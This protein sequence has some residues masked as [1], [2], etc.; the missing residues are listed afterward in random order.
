[1]IV[2]ATAAFLTFTE[3]GQGVVSFL[4]GEFASLFGFVQEIIG[5]ISDAFTAGDW[6][7]AAAIAWA[8]VLVAWEEA[9]L[10][11]FNSWNSMLGVWDEVWVG[12]VSIFDGVIVGIRS[13][14]ASLVGWLAEKLLV[15]WGWI[16]KALS[17]VGLLSETTDIGGAVRIIAE[18]TARQQKELQDAK[19]GR[20]AER[21]AG[22]AAR[23]AARGAGSTEGVTAARDELGKLIAD[24]HTKAAVVIAARE[25]EDRKKK[26][27]IVKPDTGAGGSM[28]SA[29][30]FSSS[31]LAA[32]G[33]GG[34]PMNRLVQVNE[35]QKKLAEKQ[36][37]EAMGTNISLAKLNTM[38]MIGP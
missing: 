24:A 34:G 17:A 20:D 23:A 7:L 33:Q 5:G 6:K 15:V 35:D 12:M 14:W 37:K 36:L 1:L 32:M 11:L 31:A 3:T 22:L 29:A 26:P 19:A 2:G 25:S 21:G 27:V 10:A 9:K 16:E 38:F 4:Q 18:D 28:G 8:G 30:T 13:K